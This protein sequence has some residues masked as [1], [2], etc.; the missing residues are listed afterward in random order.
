MTHHDISL[1]HVMK[2]MQ[3]NVFPVIT[4]VITVICS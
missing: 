3:N 4:Y 1:V 2:C